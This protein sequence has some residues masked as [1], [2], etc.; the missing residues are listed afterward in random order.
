MANRKNR[1]YRSR[2]ETRPA[3]AEPETSG[4]KSEPE[5]PSKNAG[6]FE[7]LFPELAQIEKEHHHEVETEEAAPGA[8]AEKDPYRY[9]RQENFR[10][11]LILSK[12]NLAQAEEMIRRNEMS[13]VEIRIGYSGDEDAQ[14]Y[15]SATSSFHTNRSYYAIRCSLTFSR[16]RIVYA[17]CGSWECSYYTAG[18][19][20]NPRLCPHL[21]AT[22]I[23]TE[24]YL[25]EHHPGDATNLYGQR[26]MNT[27]LKK[28]ED[29][30]LTTSQ[31]AP[32]SELKIEP[33]VTLDDANHLSVSFKTGSGK[34]YKIR[35]IEDFVSAVQNHK[36]MTFGKSTTLQ[37]GSEYFDD[38]SKEWL[39]YIISFLEEDEERKERRNLDNRF[40]YSYKTERSLGGS[41]PLYGALLDQFFEKISGTRVEFSVPENG[42]KVKKLFL[43]QEGA[44]SL[45]L[46]LHADL[47]ESGMF[48]GIALTGRA[49]DTIDGS[50]ASYYIHD[51]GFYRVSRESTRKLAPLLDAVQDGRIDIRIGRNN[52][53]DFYYKTLP[54]IRDLADIVEYDTELIAAYI[55]PKPVFVCYL[56]LRDDHII[57][58]A[59]A[60]YGNRI[61]LLTDHLK[62][63]SGQPV[64]WQ[65]YQDPEQEYTI[66]SILTK[67]LP[68]WDSELNILFSPREEESVYEFLAQGLDELMDYCEIHTTD[69]FRR[70]K[71]HRSSRF[72]VGVSM[73][74]DLLN[75]QLTSNDLSP[76]ELMEIFRSYHLKRKF[77]RLT[78]GDYFQISE[79]ETLQQL[80]EMMA[81]LGL[82]LKDFVAG[83]MHIPA[84]RALYLDKML[85]QT[86]DIYADRDRHFKKLIKEFK[87]V[88]DADFDFPG[89]MS[90][91]LRKYQREG[92]RW[93]RTLDSYHF[94]GILADEMG[95]G[96]TLQAI[97]V[98]AAC[99]EESLKLTGLPETKKLPA[100]KGKPETA[101]VSAAA[102]EVSLVV[103]PA[104][105]VYNWDAEFARFAPGL[106]VAIVAGTKAAR[107]E[108]I[109]NYG[110][111]DVL[112][113]SYDLLKR[114]ILHYEGKSFRYQILDEAQFIK[115]RSTAAA[116]SVKLIQSRTRYALTGTPIENRLAELWSIFDYL[117]PGFLYDY[118]QFQSEF[119]VPIVKNDDDAARE[120]L[121]KM[122]S[123][124][125]LRRRKRDVLKDLPEKLEEIRYANMEDKQRQ[126]YDAQV[127]RM[128]KDLQSKDDASFR[129]S[130]IQILAELT[131]IRQICCDPTLLFS[132][133]NGA[134]AKTEACMDL[135]HSVVEGEHKAL[136]FSQ[137]T[138]MLEILEEKLKAEGI[139]YYKI[140][141]SVPKE[142]RLQMVNAFNEDETPVFLISLKAG[143]TGLNLT[144]ADV[145]I[146]YDPWWNLAVQNQATDR[147]H[148]IGQKNIVTVYRLIAKGT[149]EEKIVEM[150][151]SKKQLAEDILSGEAVASTAISREELLSLLDS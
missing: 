14:P 133:Y 83:R 10:K 44:I 16:D 57:C 22:L 18:T 89:E 99:K 93:L 92:Y 65:P 2:G 33:S 8:P 20:L 49:P 32:G 62:A 130:R 76:E 13:P 105:L 135:I 150:Q 131:R 118:S 74:N 40:G 4:R 51:N 42:R 60:I 30:L 58:R 94:G 116:K 23:L 3:K 73:D 28:R 9:F 36:E 81:T 43:A 142:K 82:S 38:A 87:T 115:N 145:V 101:V 59:D 95:L 96:K 70:L 125:I 84:Y 41:I 27:L 11:G 45:Q 48:H 71:L 139:S 112:V 103:C 119:E 146:H 86:Q 90:T 50:S 31:S 19:M 132:D 66:L 123:P 64:V 102:P 53:A 147:A 114:D 21:I 109:H 46:E 29:H 75:L 144:G 1:L 88:E 122:T 117:M 54:L 121:R 137:F 140:T 17:N 108:I 85:E 110:N 67:Y 97:A 52:L 34:L 120:R 134:S 39:Y 98:L 15:G 143:G 26:M 151:E 138:T 69:S 12:Q 104:S 149:I 35:Q 80:I 56:D 55:P 25:K 37:M 136:V 124:F 106:S 148:R 141:G 78:N 91:I 128:R 79:N 61:H 129:Q 68:N 7:T 24:Q 5:P 127:V 6:Y 72:D 100:K 77:T 111:Y 126:L 47:D 113:T 63:Q 107:E